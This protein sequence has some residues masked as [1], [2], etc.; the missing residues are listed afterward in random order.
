MENQKAEFCIRNSCNLMLSVLKTKYVIRFNFLFR[1]EKNTTAMQIL[2]SLCGIF[3]VHLLSGFAE[4]LKCFIESISIKSKKSFLEVCIAREIYANA[5][6]S[7]IFYIYRANS[8][9][10]FC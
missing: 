9:Y 7:Y 1:D 8:K 10:I 5:I 6:Y 2:Y 3:P 4:R